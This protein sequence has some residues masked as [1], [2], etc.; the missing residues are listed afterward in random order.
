MK[1]FGSVSDAKSLFGAVLILQFS[2]VATLSIGHPLFGASLENSRERLNQTLTQLKS[3]DD[4]FE[5]TRS[6][7]DDGQKEIE[8]QDKSISL[9]NRNLK[10]TGLNLT[11]TKTAI[12]DLVK[13][14]DELTEKSHAQSVLIAETIRSAA[15]VQNRGFI[16]TMLGQ[17]NLDNLDRLTKYH[18]YI[19]QARIKA[20]D[21]YETTTSELKE[22]ILR[23]ELERKNYAQQLSDLKTRQTTLEIEQKA[24]NKRNKQIHA[25]LVEKN[26]EREVLD[27][28]R[29]RFE[30]LIDQ[31][32]QQEAQLSDPKLYSGE[33]V[34]P[35]SGHLTHQ[36]GESRAGGRLKWDG[37]FLT[38]EAGTPIIA[39]AAGVVVFADWLRGFGLIAII[40][41]GAKQMTLYGHCDV[42]YKSKGE[43]VEVGES[44]GAIGQSGGTTQNG[45]FFAVRSNGKPVDPLKQL[46]KL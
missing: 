14:I 12:S 10:T 33:L 15:R 9:L 25:S 23:L 22:T 42:L 17:E 18:G 7:L 32:T 30:E 19:A 38:A 44:I 5:N 24:R 8:R 39:A 20:F 29:K 31:I 40:D 43:R 1:P 4:W 2:I 13:S 41:H 37:I 27:R 6:E 35:V 28:N 34:W 21:R 3:L 26:K 36:F 16:Y 46:P 11:K 45:L